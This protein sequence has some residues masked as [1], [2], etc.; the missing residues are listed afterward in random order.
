MADNNQARR[1][2]EGAFLENDPFA[3]LTRIMGHDPR[4]QAEQPQEVAPAADASTGEDAGFGIDL[5]QELLDGLGFETFD[6][7]KQP[8]EDQGFAEE[9][10]AFSAPV[11]PPAHD[12]APDHGQ[13]DGAEAEYAAHE[14]Q[15]QYDDAPFSGAPGKDFADDQWAEPEVAAIVPEDEPLPRQP[16]EEGDLSFEAETF[17]QDDPVADWQSEPVEDAGWLARKPS[18]DERFTEDASFSAV[19][20]DFGGEAVEPP[21]SEAPPQ[22]AAPGLSLEDELSA[23]LGGSSGDRPATTDEDQ[24]ADE[25]IFG[26]E[27]Q[28]PFEATQAH[29]EPVEDA[30]PQ[31]PS[32]SDGHAMETGEG[33]YP[34]SASQSDDE[35]HYASTDEVAP[36][37]DDEDLFADNS[38]AAALGIGATAAGAAT[39]FGRATPHQPVEPVAFHHHSAAEDEVPATPA[40]PNH[41]FEPA[42]AVASGSQAAGA[43]DI[44]TVSIERSLVPPAQDFSVPD[45]VEPEEPAQTRPVDDFDAEF[46]DAF[47]ALDT[48]AGDAPLT[49]QPAAEATE[50]ALAAGYPQQSADEAYWADQTAPYHEQAAYAGQDYAFDEP[51]DDYAPAARHVAGT[52]ARRRR[53]LMVAGAVAAVALIGAV[54]VIGMSFFGGGGGEPVLI[55]ADADPTRVRPENPGGTVVPNQE[56]EAYQRVAEGESTAPPS[57]EELVTS[58]EE[59]VDVRSGLAQETPPL[60]APGVSEE[61]MPAL[62]PDEEAPLAAAPAERSQERIAA[63]E[64]GAEAA[65]DDFVAVAPRRVR[66]MIVRPDGTMVPREETETPPASPISATPQDEP[67]A[68]AGDQ[69]A[70]LELPGGSNAADAEEAVTQLMAAAPAAIDTPAAPT[71]SDVTPAAAPQAAAPAGAEA[72]EWS[73]QIASQP[74]AESA[75]STYQ[76]L[77]RRYGSILEGRA[78][79]IVRADIPDRGTYY[80]VRIPAS[81]RDDAVQLCTRYQAAGGNCF[82]SR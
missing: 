19:D 57:Q 35:A 12:H 15:P 49:G 79:N 24:P 70:S 82:V 17:S 34:A 26:N 3:E 53:G 30:A 48:E 23:I 59:P 25:A 76:D 36:A 73:M 28:E 77:A 37:A 80:R 20:M 52:Q 54:G 46:A 11:S 4:K 65:G 81:S 51:E 41:D 40:S 74:S 14:R 72:S 47:G 31:M 16:A 44:E 7:P 64:T 1:S 2:D 60:L 56:S 68:P 29:G 75:Q 33:A 62:G 63:D 50:A 78:V 39:M 55:R 5:E 27:P 18:P 9:A 22:P 66:T 58:A 8:A 43:P 6:Q 67:A 10:P 32:E 61:D 71:A 69:G 21:A 42:A 13:G 38:L 45:L